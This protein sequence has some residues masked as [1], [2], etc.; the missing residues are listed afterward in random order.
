MMAPTAKKL[1]GADFSTYRIGGPLEEAY[2]PES[3]E[4]AIEVL[5]HARQS[6]KKLTV[7]GWGGN[8]LIASA[9]IS[10]VTL[11]TRKM[12]WVKRLDET[13]FVFGAGAHLA[14]MS[15]TAH[16]AGLAGAEFMI[17]IPGTLGGAVRMNAGAL[18]QETKDVLVNVTLFNV[19]TG[20]V[21]VWD[22]ERLNFSY[23]KSEI[24]PS[25]HIV[26]EGEL[27]FRPGDKAQ[28]KKVMDESVNFR[29]TH[30]PKEPNG[31]SVFK[32]PRPD[33]PMGRL[34]EA[35]GGKG[36]WR[37]GGACVS[38]LHGNFIINTGTATSTDVLRLMLRMKRA[39][40]EKYGLETHPENLFLGDATD[41]EQAMWEELTNG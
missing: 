11:I 21:E 8:S 29:K 35:L 9:G 15:S 32:N 7:L 41:E 38:P 40:H 13:H 27:V 26:L 4:E 19:E 6:R 22:R 36:D 3:L 25:R 1:D 16:Q 39:V 12:D 31:G 28:V 2:V 14:K 18:G 5:R 17:G 30:H 24:D 20:E 33:M 34:I 37:E 10:G 23:R